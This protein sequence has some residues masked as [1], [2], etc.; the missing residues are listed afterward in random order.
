LAGAVLVGLAPNLGLT[1]PRDHAET[2]TFAFEDADVGKVADEILG[3]AIG[4]PYTV[5]PGLNAKLTFRIDRR[6]TK[7][8]LL[9]AFEAALATQDIVMVRQGG[10]LLIT[11][12]AKA[13]GAAGLETSATAIH[14]AGYQTLAVPLAYATPSEVAKAL[15]AVSPNNNVVVYV[16]DNAGLLILGGTGDELDAALQ[17]IHV[18]DKSSIEGSK[19]RW[20]ELDQADAT[21]VAGEL[22][23]VLHAIGAGSVTIVPLKRLNGLFVFGR[24]AEVLDTVAGWVQKLDVAPKWTN[25]SLWVYHPR[26]LSADALASTLD[27]LLLGETASLTGGPPSR[28]GATAA[29][30]IGRQIGAPATPV[31]NLAAPPPQPAGEPPLGPMQGG[32]FGDTGEGP[33]RIGYEKETNTLLIEASQARWLQIQKILDQIDLTPGQ[34]LIEAS[35]LEVTLNDQL[36]FGVDWS[37]LADAGRV[38]VSSIPNGT[39]VS[40]QLPGLAAAI[41]TKNVSAAISTLGTR[42]NVDVVSSPKL[43][44][45][46][47]HTAKL[48][49]GDQV[50]VVSQSAVDTSAPG[51][52]VVNAINYA[53][54][55]VIMNVTPRIT[56]DDRIFLDVSE[57][58][59][60]ATE[61]DTSGI[62][63]PTIQQRE[64]DSSVVLADGGTVALGGLISTTRSRSDSGVPYL[65]DAPWIGNLFKSKSNQTQRDELIVL[66][67]AT[68]IK[69]QPAFDK[70]LARLKED[71]HDVETHGLFKPQP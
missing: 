30:P 16:D 52:P 37:V 10:S 34:V 62:D 38:A 70:A 71:M 31:A 61:T 41:L 51:S 11:S 50:P 45:L 53:N 55:G 3:Q 68:I 27:M 20:F 57:Q 32:A 2:Y 8:Q 21:A 58:V 5:D 66:I 13:K 12:R 17:M 18:F 26:N 15:A 35:I 56:G 63:S 22:L 23:P 33:V 65:K 39:S 47:N 1:A 49:V 4:V 25:A 7:D 19:L 46:D 60:T 28:S 48:Q 36:K 9:K 14:H 6:L 69:D 42:T 43:I 54:T 29:G 40:A 67:T 59:S 44:V 24:S 64:F